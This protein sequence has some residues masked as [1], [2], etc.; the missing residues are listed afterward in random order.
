[1]QVRPCATARIAAKSSSID[2]ALQD[3]A[4][5]ARLLR[6]ANVAKLV[7]NREDDDPRL[8]DGPA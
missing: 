6:G 2:R 1:M 8:S 5:G 7:V 3:V 4:D